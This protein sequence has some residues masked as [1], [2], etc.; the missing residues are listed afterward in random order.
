MKKETKK[1]NKVY[2]ILVQVALLFAIG[3]LL[4]GVITY[5]FMRMTSNEHIETLMEGR[6]RNLGREV[7]RAVKEFPNYN[8]L[9]KYWHDHDKE[10]DIEYDVNY[11]KSTLTYRKYLKWMERHPDT[12][13]QYAGYGDIKSMSAEDQKLYAEIAYSWLI[14]R[15][16]E[17]KRSNGGLTDK[18]SKNRVAYLYVCLTDSEFKTQYFLLSGSDPGVERGTEFNQT[19]TLGVEYEVPAQITKGMK[20]ARSKSDYLAYSR[21]TG[22]IDY[23]SYIGSMDEYHVLVGITYEAEGIAQTANKQ[24]WQRTRLTAAL[25]I[26][27]ALICLAAIFL[28]VLRP[29]RTIQKNIRKYRETKDSEAVAE[30]LAEIRTHS[31]NEMSEL[32]TDITDLS[33]AM[34]KYVEEI[35]VITAE[36][37]RIGTELELGSQIQASMLPSTFP[38]FPDNDEIDIYASMTPAKEVGGD[39]Y[40]FFF[41]DED[42]LCINI[43]DVSGKGIPAALFM[44]AS[45]II[46]AN[47][48]KMDKS[49]AEILTDTNNSISSNNQQEMFVTVWLGI[50]ELS[51]GKL[52]AANAGHEYPTLMQPG[53]KFE[54]IKDKH[55]FVI[56]GM[57]GVKYTEYELQMDP[58]SKLFVYTDGV[59]EATNAENELF[60]TDRM[61]DALNKNT[62]ATPYEVLQNVQD[63]VDAFVKEAEQFDDLT[64]LCV[65]YKGP[66]KQDEA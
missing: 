34:D 23:Y 48:A 12:P 9:I 37:Q 27:L 44:M 49:P 40:D 22:Y 5:V 51:T 8:W 1:H 11:D 26:L 64:M 53:G 38:A 47:N 4:T 36:K 65:S 58:G 55:G 15:M 57:E 46:L 39:F 16:N 7:E 50:L 18:R 32:A 13:I 59:A 10:M 41:V 2:G 45:K 60:G 3:T 54:L 62:D 14:T 24:T 56:G 6:A 29:L 30:A 21:D 52:V 20:D 42:H 17:I 35:Q 19:Y 25:Q 28:F 31:H 63:G 33:K 61:L 43:A 66:D